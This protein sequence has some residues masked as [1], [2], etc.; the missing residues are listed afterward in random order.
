MVRHTCL[1][2]NLSVGRRGRTSTPD[3]APVSPLLL[4]PASPSVFVSFIS[5]CERSIV[6]AVNIR[7]RKVFER[8]PGLPF[9][10]GKIQF[11]VTGHALEVP[12]RI[13]YK[14]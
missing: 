12:T 8:T 10:S 14:D 6:L 7:S 11:L 4:P 3:L 1:C 5:F 2:L 13:I 9:L